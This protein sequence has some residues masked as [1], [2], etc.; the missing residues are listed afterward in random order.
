MLA[1]YC[2]A[3][4]A[5][6]KGLLSRIALVFQALIL[7]A[8]PI[9]FGARG[10]TGIAA[11]SSALAFV[12][13]LKSRKAK[14]GLMLVSTVIVFAA[15]VIG[16]IAPLGTLLPDIGRAGALIPQDILA[17]PSFIGRANQLVDAID[18]I[19]AHPF[20]GEGLGSTLVFEAT[21][22][23]VKEVAAIDQGFAYVMSKLGILGLASF[24]ALVYSV[25]KR[26]GWPETNRV[27]IAAFV[28]FIFS[29]AFMVSHPVNAAIHRS[30]I[31]RYHCWVTL[32][33]ALSPTRAERPVSFFEYVE[34]AAR[35]T[36]L[37]ELI[38]RC[39]PRARSS[40]CCSTL[41][42]RPTGPSELSRAWAYEEDT[43]RLVESLL[44]PDMTSGAQNCKPSG[45]RLAQLCA[46]FAP[47][48]CSTYW[49]P[50]MPSLFLC[51]T[52]QEDES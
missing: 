4:A 42:I 21:W 10:A 50:G 31:C 44:R 19:K 18:V 24:Y 43:T 9:V 28:L 49:P 8:Q 40:R 39:A 47:V 1:A 35:T 37:G 13:L 5:M 52:S 41:R 32:S 33:G 7:I 22:G 34:A 45:R 25:F 26:S 29:I 51:V 48:K 3:E 17:D 6:A 36:A 12:M 15:I 27:H 2:M 20:L 23:G 14:A 46:R 30:R 38:H 16:F 11:V